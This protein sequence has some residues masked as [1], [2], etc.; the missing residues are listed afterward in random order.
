SPL[1]SPPWS[2]PSAPCLCIYICP[3]LGVCAHI[4]CLVISRLQFR[5]LKS[6]IFWVGI[7]LRKI[8]HG[9]SEA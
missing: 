2:Q 1:E 4:Y 7:Q 9:A 8:D 3:R 6:K 5:V